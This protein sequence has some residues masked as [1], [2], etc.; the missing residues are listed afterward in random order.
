MLFMTSSEF[1]EKEH[2]GTFIVMIF[3]RTI[4]KR[5]PAYSKP[6]KKKISVAKKAKESSSI[7]FANE[8]VQIR[9]S[10]MRRFCNYFLTLFNVRK[11]NPF[12]QFIKPLQVKELKEKVMI[13]MDAYFKT[14]N[15]EDGAL[16]RAKTMKQL[17][18]SDMP[19]DIHPNEKI[20]VSPIKERQALKAQPSISASSSQSRSLKHR[21]IVSHPDQDADIL[22]PGYKVEPMKDANAV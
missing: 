4:K 9:E 21:S 20:L 2:E 10:K 8:N 12:V 14:A 17:E 7:R 5:Q 6:Q 18:K 16:Q 1:L 15:N 19:P 22:P 11:L 3:E 13:E